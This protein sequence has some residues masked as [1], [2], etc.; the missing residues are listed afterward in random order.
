MRQAVIIADSDPRKKV[1]GGIGIYSGNLAD[2]LSSHGYE[3]LFLAKRQ[4]GEEIRK[5]HY[6]V[7]EANRRPGESN[8]SFLM[9]LFRRFPIQPD[10]VINAQ[11]PD[12]IIPFA[13]H[14]GRKI[15]TLNGSHAKNVALKK[16]KLAGFLFGILE[17]RGLSAADSIISVS[18][19]NTQYYSGKYPGLAGKIRTI[20]VGIDISRFVRSRSRR[21]EYG[22]RKDEKVV[23]Y[24]GRFEREKNLPLLIDS[25]KS[26]GCRLLL[27]G[28]GKEEQALR[29]LAGKETVFLPS[30]PNEE[31]PD[32]LSSG[33]VF[34]VSSLYEGL[35]NAALE[36]LACGLPII[37]TP[38]GGMPDI[39]VE[40]KTGSLAG[41]DEYADKLKL[42]LKDHKRYAHACKMMAE[43]YSADK[44]FP[45]VMRLY[46]NL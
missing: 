29:Q 24:V 28:S 38:V 8:I 26:A 44:M 5:V 33:D 37:S 27:V 40:G 11:R 31:V 19:E 39:V 17:K 18:K 12:W 10:A 16:G 21:E 30:V 2:Y 41:P 14:K 36:A 3:V 43:N 46:E 20:P 9:S 13:F 45:E 35:P 4:E 25:C 34:A 23:V 6:D 42:L 1:I 15:V 7:I 22:F 32:I